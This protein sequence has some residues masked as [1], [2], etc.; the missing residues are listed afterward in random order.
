MIHDPLYAVQISLR[1][2]TVIFIDNHRVL[3]ARTSFE[4]KSRKLLVPS[5]LRL[6]LFYRRTSQDVWM[7]HVER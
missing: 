5:E 6:P 1:P 7:L 4:R 2:G 3:H